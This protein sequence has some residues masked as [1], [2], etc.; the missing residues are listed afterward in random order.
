[1]TAS[2]PNG[3]SSDDL[4]RMLSSARQDITDAKPAGE[5]P[6]GDQ[7]LT[8][9]ELEAL[10]ERVIDASLEECNDPM[11][12]KVIVIT[13]CYRFASWHTKIGQTCFEKGQTAAGACWLRD[14]GKFQSMLD[15]L[16]SIQIGEDDFT[17]VHTQE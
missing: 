11:L 10:A 1:M 8:Q 2:I 5:G 14:A 13:L 17:C 15:T 4:E 16:M 7:G 12:H 6:Y 3:F 9:S